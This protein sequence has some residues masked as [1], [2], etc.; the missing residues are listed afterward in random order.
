VA[1]HAGRTTAI[2]AQLARHFNEGRDWG[3]AFDYY[4]QAGDHS[5]TLSAALEAEGHYGQ[6]IGLASADG[7]DIES[8]R[9]A[10]AYYKRA[11]TRVFLGNFSVAMADYHEALLGASKASDQDLMFEIRLA[12]AYT[13]GFAGRIADATK[14]AA[15]LETDTE[16]PPGGLKRLSYLI[17]DLQLKMSHGDLDQAA[18][19]GDTAVA[20][21]R[22]LGDFRRLRS[23]LCVRA[24]IHYYRAEY[25][26]ALTQLREVCSNPGAGAWRQADPR[27]RYVH[28]SGV[29]FLGFTLGDLGRVSEAVSILQSELELARTDGYGY[30]VPILKNAIAWLYGEIG[31]LDA[32]LRLAEE[33]S[34]ETADQDIEGRIESQLNMAAALSR[35]GHLD[36][37]VTL[38]DEADRL[39]K[40]G[41]PHEWFWR[42]HCGI[43]AAEHALTLGVPAVAS[44]RAREAAELARRHGAWKQLAIA[45]RLLAE[46]AAARGAWAQAGTH[47]EEAVDLLRL[48]PVPIVAWKVH[49]TAARI[50]QQR[51]QRAEAAA[52]LD[53]ARAEVRHLAEGIQEEQ[54]KMTFL[55]LHDVHQILSAAGLK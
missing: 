18:V 47:V 39:M 44:D 37:A 33:A 27:P 15:D 49:A 36:P 14:A 9:I 30:W 41:I 53:R 16:P 48:H 21:A 50:H 46:A 23:S 34:K 43:V 31:E 24:R 11:L 25:E 35:L 32:A 55:Q 26:S 40:Q 51:G 8:G 19:T 17:L 45:E 7:T 10:V 38:L 13:H 52:A 20:L 22:S 4:V 1:L 29:Q 28:F 3:R 54:L 5:M 12:I 2:A 6:A 42:I